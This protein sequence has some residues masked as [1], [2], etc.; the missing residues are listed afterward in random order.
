MVL[1]VVIFLTAFL[2]KRVRHNSKDTRTL[3]VQAV[4]SMTRFFLPLKSKSYFLRIQ[5]SKNGQ[6]IDYLTTYE[7]NFVHF[8]LKKNLFKIL[9]FNLNLVL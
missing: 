6:R 7:K 8:P 1:Q 5:R 3:L 9:I 2:F 4:G